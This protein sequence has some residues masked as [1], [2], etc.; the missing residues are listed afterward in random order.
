MSWP[1][2]RKPWRSRR[3]SYFCCVRYLGV[4][5]EGYSDILR[6]SLIFFEGC[7][8]NAAMYLLYTRPTMYAHTLLEQRY[9]TCKP[10]FSFMDVWRML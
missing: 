2:V 3:S 4:V 7:E 1:G 8:E 9:L 6:A 5:W 10:S